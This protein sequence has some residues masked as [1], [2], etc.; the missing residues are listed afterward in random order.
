MKTKYY[1]NEAKRVVISVLELSRC[2]GDYFT[3]RIT[4]MAKCDPADEWDEHT[5]KIIANTRAHIIY[6]K[7][8]L[9]YRERYLHEI[10]KER[11]EMIAKID[12]HYNVIMGLEEKLELMESSI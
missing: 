5:G 10:N 9:K 8:M 6:H 1:I 4:G 7:E 2:D 12:H 11:H 3:G